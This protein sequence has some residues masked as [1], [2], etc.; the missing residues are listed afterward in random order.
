M[1]PPMKRV[2]AVGLALPALTVTQGASAQDGDNVRVGP[3]VGLTFSGESN[4]QNAIS[5]ITEGYSYTY[6]T[7]SALMR[8][9]LGIRFDRTNPDDPR[10]HRIVEIHY[11]QFGSRVGP[12]EISKHMIS[13]PI[14]WQWD[15]KGDH[16]PI[17]PHW[18]AG[19]QASFRLATRASSRFA[20]YGAYLAEYWNG[21]GLLRQPVDF[22]GTVGFGVSFPVENTRANLDLRLYHGIVPKNSPLGV[23]LNRQVGVFG[24]IT[25]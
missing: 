4:V 11:T 10:K 7:A 9:A 21:Y 25:F 18:Q 5:Q 2:L 22:G 8:P 15:A 3:V 12:F 19:V 13:A 6:F 23:S 24:G 1:A 20:V 17:T 16:A 14:I